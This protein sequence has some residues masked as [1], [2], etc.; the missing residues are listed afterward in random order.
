MAG[1][2]TQAWH[3]RAPG[4]HRRSRSRA[5]AQA[6]GAAHSHVGFHRRCLVH[7]PRP[8]DGVRNRGRRVRPH[9]RYRP[10]PAGA[11]L[12]FSGLVYFC[13]AAAPFGSQPRAPACGWPGQSASLPD[14][15]SI[16][17]PWWRQCWPFWCW[18]A[19][20]VSALIGFKMLTK[21]ATVPGTPAATF[22]SMLQAIF[23]RFVQENVPITSVMGIR[24]SSRTP[25]SSRS[26]MGIWLEMSWSSSSLLIIRPVQPPCPCISSVI[27]GTTEIVRWLRTGRSAN[28]AG[29]APR[30]PS[31]PLS[32]PTTFARR[33]LH[34]QYILG[35]QFLIRLIPLRQVT[36]S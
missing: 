15:V 35:W 9:R 12:G 36:A 4:C 19:S 10:Y 29:A 24:A 6:D 26:S 5:A 21:R 30:V 27:I 18:L 2:T 22:A 20:G 8:A 13:T 1:I 33:P 7:P 23:S 11:G 3:R 31:K 14:S 16:F 17:L 34:H 28:P 32:P 25:S